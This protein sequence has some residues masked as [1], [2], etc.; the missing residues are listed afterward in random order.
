MSKFILIIIFNISTVLV[1]YDYDPIESQPESC[2]DYRGYS[3]GAVGRT[4]TLDFLNDCGRPMYIGLCLIDHFG[5]AEYR[6][7]KKPLKPERRWKVNTFPTFH[8][9]SFVWAYDPYEAPRPA[10][11]LEED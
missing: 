8:L 7:T 6:Y 5:D 4:K 9:E 3:G 11:C 10:P 2:I 1:S